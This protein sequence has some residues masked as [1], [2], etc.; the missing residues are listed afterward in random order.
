MTPNV[1]QNLAC[2]VS[3]D[4]L[5]QISNVSYNMRFPILL[6][7]LLGSLVHVGYY[8]LIF[9]IKLPVPTVHRGSHL[10]LTEAHIL[11]M[12]VHVWAVMK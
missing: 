5:R 2:V 10:C 7:K 11:S 9:A 4:K 3:G 6:T 1:L 12:Y 8:F